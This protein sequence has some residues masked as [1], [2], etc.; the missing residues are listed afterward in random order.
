MAA[1][2]LQD[3]QTDA[4]DA[5]VRL[6]TDVYDTLAAAKG[7]STVEAQAHWHGLARSALFRLRSGGV[8]RLDTAMRIA[9]DLGVAVE[10]IW[11]R[12]S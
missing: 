6:R 5:T 7:Y 3:G 1:T 12:T 4:S 11:E 8:P 2:H 9:A 10:V